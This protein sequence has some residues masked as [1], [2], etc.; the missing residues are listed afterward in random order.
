MLPP[1]LIS[2][3]VA[4][5]NRLGVVYMITGSVASGIYIHVRFTNDIDVVAVLSDID[6][7]K[8][9]TAFD[10][11]AFYVRPLE[12]IHLERQRPAQAI[13]T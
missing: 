3:F 4:P 5:V 2:L 1:D 11:P 6:A 13:S 7:V 9:H 10:T 8:L 12:V